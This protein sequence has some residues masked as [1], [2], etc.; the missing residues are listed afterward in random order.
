VSKRKKSPLRKD[1]KKTDSKKKL[2]LSDKIK[3]KVR[4]RSRD[5]KKRKRSA[6][7]SRSRR[8]DKS[9]RRRGRSASRGGK[10]RRRSSSR[11][12]RNRKDS[13]NRKS[14]NKRSPS[15]SKAKKSESKSPARSESRSRSKSRKT[16][17]ADKYGKLFEAQGGEKNVF[18]SGDK[19]MVS[20]NYPSVAAAAVEKKVQQP[21]VI[22]D[23]LDED[24]PYKVIEQQRELVDIANS[25]NEDEATRVG[26]PEPEKT[27]LAEKL[28]L[29]TK[30]ATAEVSEDSRPT[31][32]VLG[33]KTPPNEP[34]AE[35]E[36]EDDHQQ[37]QPKPEPTPVKGP[38]TPPE[39][40]SYDPFEP[41][42]SPD[43]EN[44]APETPPLQP[45]TP[46]MVSESP[47]RRPP[48]PPTNNSIPFLSSPTNGTG[49][50]TPEPPVITPY[51]RKPLYNS[52]PANVLSATLPDMS[53]S[54]NTSSGSP[55]DMDL[56]S[57]FS[58]GS[59]SDLSDLFEPPTGTPPGPGPAS[60][61]RP[62][63]SSKWANII[64]DKQKHKRSSSNK[65]KS[66]HS[67]SKK[68]VVNTRVVDDRLKII[69]DVP[70]SAVE[71]S[72]KEK[73]L[74]KVQRQERI[75]EEV[76]LV[77]K[78]IYNARKVSKEAYKEIL[79]KAVPKI[80]HSKNGEIIPAKIAK[81]VQGYVKKYQ[82]QAKNKSA[83]N[84]SF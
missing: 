48:S 28:K 8:K 15:R 45:E 79:R 61:S 62:S 7:R 32:V 36:E 26:L 24:A 58:P 13:R 73:F 37:E 57:P 9:R 65:H 40:D 41:T 12:N 75:V 14:K 39:P 84:N 74:A 56:D 67:R 76:K 10:R 4:S 71:M 33:P 60:A 46:P 3:K 66:S 18:T 1:G 27:S 54:L 22:I 50:S 64:G 34:E 51:T 31:E 77:L 6:S 80:C 11:R 30:T 55:V 20:V 35:H 2:P 5:G 29:V 19:I 83:I 82:H 63:E 72:V 47:P 21:S 49:P 43:E 81:L 17:D 70:S 68:T 52:L 23:I 25:D 69:D 59:G 53:R 44:M 78:P 38:M 16:S 42:D